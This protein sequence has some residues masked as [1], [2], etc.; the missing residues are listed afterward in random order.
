[1]LEEHH[2]CQQCRINKRI[3]RLPYWPISAQ[4]EV[5]RFKNRPEFEGR[6]GAVSPERNLQSDNCSR[7]SVLMS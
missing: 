2:Q 1:M 4:E 7:N 5:L 3:P 6:G